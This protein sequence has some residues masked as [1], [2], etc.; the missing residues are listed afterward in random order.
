MTG[1]D[2]VRFCEHCRKN[3]YNLSSM[4]HDEAA[5]LVRQT[6][7]RL[8]VR[9]YRRHDGTILTNDCPVGLRAARRWARTHIAGI[10]ALLGGL[11]ALVRLPTAPQGVPAVPPAINPPVPT[12]STAHDTSRINDATREQAKRVRMRRQIRQPSTRSS[13]IANPE[14]G[15]VVMGTPG[16][17]PWSPE[18]LPGPRLPGPSSPP[19]PNGLHLAP[20][21]GFSRD[22]S[23]RQ[24]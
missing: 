18:A 23:P 10:A 5:A 15:S 24:P 21:P 16:V 4:S 14:V 3:V 6:E 17:S 20:D 2:R 22:E 7:G 19:A 8:C 9:F 1:D 13:P 12:R 11:L